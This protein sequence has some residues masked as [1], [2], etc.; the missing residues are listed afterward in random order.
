MRDGSE[1]Y[2]KSYDLLHYFN[3]NTH[4]VKSAN[5]QHFSQQFEE[6]NI[7]KVMLSELPHVYDPRQWQNERAIIKS[8]MRTLQ[9]N[10]CNCKSNLIAECVELIFIARFFVRMWLKIRLDCI[11]LRAQFY[12]RI[13]FCCVCVCVCLCICLCVWKLTA[14]P[15]LIATLLLTQATFGWF[16]AKRASGHDSRN[17]K[18][19]AILW[20]R[21]HSCCSC[22]CTAMIWCSKQHDSCWCLHTF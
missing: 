1:F 6:C 20:G 7:K 13:L 8:K 10:T 3:R 12:K 9:F 4:F 5:H 21:C 17:W 2:S 15:V 11:T 16:S 14:A 22:S 19:R 18:V